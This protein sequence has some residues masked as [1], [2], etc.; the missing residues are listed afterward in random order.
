MNMAMRIMMILGLVN[1]ERRAQVVCAM[2]VQSIC[3]LTYS[4]ETLLHTDLN[5]DDDFG[6]GLILNAEHKWRVAR[7]NGFYH[8]APDLPSFK[9]TVCR[10]LSCQMCGIE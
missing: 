8:A 10:V 9:Q 3:I 7:S 5:E 6:V 1:I 2:H 4:I